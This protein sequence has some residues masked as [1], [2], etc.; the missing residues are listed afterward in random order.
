MAR[1]KC[2]LELDEIQL[3]LSKGIAMLPRVQRTYSLLL[4]S[5]VHSNKLCLIPIEKME[6][7]CDEIRTKTKVC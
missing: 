1:M 4:V 6:Q 7:F 3:W 2:D 5:L